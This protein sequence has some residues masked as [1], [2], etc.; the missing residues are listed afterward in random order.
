V[1][2]KIISVNESSQRSSVQNGI[3]EL[4]QLNAKFTVNGVYAG[5]SGFLLTTAAELVTHYPDVLA[6]LTTS[7]VIFPSSIIG[8]FSYL[9]GRRLGIHHVEREKLIEQVTATEANLQAIF[10]TMEDSIHMTSPGFKVLMMNPKMIQRLGDNVIGTD[11]FNS[12]YQ[13]EKPC[14][15]CQMDLIQQG[16]KVVYEIV[17][18]LDGRNFRSSN[19]PIYN[20]DGTISKM[21]ILTDI[22]EFKKLQKELT[23]SIS[24]LEQRE[25]DLTISEKKFKEVVDNIADIANIFKGDINGTVVY[26]NAD[27]IFE[28]TGYTKEQFASGDINWNKLVLE[29]DRTTYEQAFKDGLKKQNSTY[30]RI[31]RIRHKEGA[32]VWIYEKSKI[33]KL[34]DSSKRENTTVEGIFFDMT[35]QKEYDR[36]LTEKQILDRQIRWLNTISAGIS[37][38]FNNLLAVIIGSADML[39]DELTGNE[40]LQELASV[41]KTTS[42]KAAE[43]VKRFLRLSK[44]LYVHKGEPLDVNNQIQTSIKSFMSNNITIE[45]SL[46]S[47]INKVLSSPV[48]LQTIITNLI[49]NSVESI[50]RKKSENEE[51]I[52]IKTE[53]VRIKPADTLEHH[54]LEPG[55]YVK[56]TISDTGEGMDEKTLERLYEPYFSTKE[57]GVKKLMGLSMTEVMTFVRTYKGSI[58][59]HSKLGVGTTFEIY[60]KSSDIVSSNSEID[61]ISGFQRV[62]NKATKVLIVDDEDSLRTVYSLFLGRRGIDHHLAANGSE[63]INMLKKYK[64]EIGL[65]ILDRK[66]PDIQGDDLIDPL[67]EIKP[68]VKIVI[69]SGYSDRPTKEIE[70]KVQG[71]ID[72]P[73]NMKIFYKMIDELME[74]ES[75]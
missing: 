74:N 21:T 72:K 44:P 38:D 68:G 17:S 18:R 3:S 9:I 41:I 20:P 30:E 6:A 58:S 11:C 75:P 60:F 5:L 42:N 10:A 67:R 73:A 35:S 15:W 66:M 55:N 65:I 24:E 56:M 63:A 46:G 59:C 45:I 7:T 53:N 26:Y 25:K 71:F 29:E 22:T 50:E 49:E 52:K 12:I 39:E 47:E 36:I 19:V 69:S 14:E 13:K 2:Y 61:K 43:L 70:D 28:T 33:H 8:L 51:I 40:D 23:Q 64:D 57:L 4:R 48:L 27:K 32:V 54:E 62:E 1:R 16:K 31:Y 34:G 37:H